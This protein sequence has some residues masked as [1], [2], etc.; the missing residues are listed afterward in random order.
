M[1]CAAASSSIA[2][3]CAVFLSMGCRRRAANVAMLTWS[4]WLAE[5]G[6]LSTLAVAP[7]PPGATATKAQPA[8]S[9]VDFSTQQR[10]A[11]RHHL[12]PGVSDH[13]VDGSEAQK[14]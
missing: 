3:M 13:G 10:C 9:R 1:P 2:T 11:H 5:V 12:P 8:E 7:T 4:S 6:R 14:N